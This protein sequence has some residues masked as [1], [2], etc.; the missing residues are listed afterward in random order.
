L[1][2]F[3]ENTVHVS[4]VL[5]KD[6][7]G[8]FYISAT[9][10]PPDGFHL[11]SKDIPLSGIDGL[12]RPTYISLPDTSQLK[13]TGELL[14]SVK[15]QIPEFEPYELLVYPFGSVTL[16]LPVE[17]PAGK[18]WIQESVLVTFMAC[19]EIGCKPPV[20]EKLVFIELPSLGMLND[21]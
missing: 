13:N 14:E 11:Y 17:L 7:A 19:N 1:T 18:E 15:P 2:D 5:E 8:Q 21:E 12:G 3:T 20:V 4:I 16:R 9:F 6:T 10:T